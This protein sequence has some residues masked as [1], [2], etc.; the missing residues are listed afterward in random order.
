M[1][2]L[3]AEHISKI[4]KIGDV[5]VRA[6]QDISLSI[7][8]GDFVAIMGPSGSG[9]ST[10]MHLLG[11]LDSP[12]TGHFRLLGKETAGL[13]EEEYAFLRNRAIGFVFQQFNLMS[14]SSA[15]ENVAL[16]LLYSESRKENL[17][18]PRELLKKVGLGERINHR[19][20]ELSGGQQQRV[21]IARA[22]ANN[23]YMILADEP[24][25]NLD[26]KAGKEIMEIFR[27]LH[28]Q[29]MTIALVTHD[30]N[31][32]AQ[33]ERVIRMSDGRIVSDEKIQSFEKKDLEIPEF[34][35]G[36]SSRKKYSIGELKEHFRQASRVLLNNKLRSALS[37][38][39]V[40][41]GVAC[42]IT[43]LAL[44]RGAGESIR[45]DLS[46]MGSNL[47][48][49]RPG[50]IKV[51]GASVD[52]STATRFTVEDAKAMTQILTVSKV[53]PQVRGSAQL[54]FGDKNWSSR[55]MG[56]VPEYASMKNQEPVSGRFFTNDENQSRQRVALIGKTV[57]DNL[58]GSEDPVGRTIRINRVSFQI[59]GVLPSLGSSGFQDEDDV[60][61]IPLMTAMRRLLGKEYVD[62]IDV[63]V[64]SLDKMSEAQ[65]EINQLIIRRHRL[66]PDKYDSF[67]IRN[68][69]DLQ[70]AI[71]NTTRTFSVLLGSVAAISLV[72]GGI[73]IMN[74]MLV[75]VKERT[76]EIGLRKALGATPDDILTQ[77]LVEA[78]LVTFV[79]G[80]A[81]I[82]LASGISWTIAT[83]ANW[84]MIIT[85][86]S[87][88]LAFAFSAG[89]GIVFGLWPA[90][91]AAMLDPIRAL[92]YE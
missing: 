76:R 92:R 49:I 36:T 63:E 48:I 1:K 42:V 58:F 38:L 51:R 83:F 79:G 29:G 15:A 57:K 56:V 26:S 39:G 8:K 61:L 20:N 37:M 65:E 46:K 32:A 71:Q 72:V 30:E 59:L 43:M 2:L 6:L 31:L 86:T 55:V 24:T 82:F 14:R 28:R 87:L 22:L 17:D 27:D 25:G 67:F 18:I 4:Y 21:A 13:R 9:K 85:P 33:A 66:T 16:P 7:E 47:L 75:S 70:A 23:P 34:N 10:L 12:D 68:M 89:V 62:Q 45:E 44:G 80:L 73:G 74:I 52:A 19:P 88:I 60:V 5:E 81:G 11:F 77:F 78:V 84:K 54:V 53:S 64:V 91:Q 69:A 90:K 40:L 3:E 41:I 50:S 35:H